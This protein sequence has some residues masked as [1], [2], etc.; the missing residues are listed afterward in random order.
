MPGEAM[1]ATTRRL[2]PAL[3]LFC[4][5]FSAPASALETLQELPA[6]LTL[7]WCLERGREAN[8]SL[9]RAAAMASEAHHRIAS[10]RAF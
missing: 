9:E 8:P 1:M 7:T 10:E 6:P 5:A 4:A 2:T 3:F